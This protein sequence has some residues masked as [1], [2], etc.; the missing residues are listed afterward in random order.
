ML[1]KLNNKEVRHQTVVWAVVGGKKLTVHWNPMLSAHV[2]ARLPPVASH[3]H[4]DHEPLL[5]AGKVRKRDA[6]LH[7]LTSV[8]ALWT[9]TQTQ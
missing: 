1:T 7:F 6:G 8:L 4:H 3:R 5:F 9:L 2:E